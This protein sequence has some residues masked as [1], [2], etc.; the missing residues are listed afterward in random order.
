MGLI[1]ETARAKLGQS[2]FQCNRVVLA[3]VEIVRRGVRAWSWVRFVVVKE[4]DI[5]GINEPY[6]IS[7]INEPYSICDSVS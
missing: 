3:V 2:C 4:D 6:Y 5:S 7:G 1:K